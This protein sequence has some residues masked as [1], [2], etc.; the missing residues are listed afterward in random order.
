[1]K[2]RSR[3]STDKSTGLVEL[4]VNSIKDTLNDGHM[5]QYQWEEVTLWNL[6]IEISRH[7]LKASPTF[8]G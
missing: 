2:C 8:S 5:E 7:E 6:L 3:K 4:R 1:M